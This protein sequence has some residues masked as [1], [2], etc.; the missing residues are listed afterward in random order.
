VTDLEQAKEIALKSGNNFHRK[1]VN[2]FESK[3]WS[4]LVSPSYLD[5]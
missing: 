4:T 5:G 2:Y 1:V 3:G